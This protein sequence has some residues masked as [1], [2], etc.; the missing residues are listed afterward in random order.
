MKKALI[1]V[2]GIACLSVLVLTCGDHTKVDIPSGDDHFEVLSVDSVAFPS[3]RNPSDSWRFEYTKMDDVW[4]DL[5][6]IPYLDEIIVAVIDTGVNVNHPDLNIMSEGYDFLDND[7]DPT[8]YASHGTHVAG[9]IGAKKNLGSDNVV[10]IAP[11]V[12]ILPLKVF[13]DS[14]SSSYVAM[15]KAIDYAIEMD[16]DVINISM[17][18]VDIDDVRQAVERAEAAGVVVVAA[19]GNF[20]NHWVNGSVYHERYSGKDSYT[21]NMM[22]PAAN[23][24]VLAVG[25]ISKNRSTDEVAIADYSNVG[26]VIDGVYRGVDV[27]A[28]GSGIK[29]TNYTSF[30]SARN[31]SGTSMAAPHVSGMV[32]LLLA[33]YP[34]LTPAEVRAII[35]KTAYDP[36]IVVPDHYSAQDRF[37]AIGNGIIDINAALNFSPLNA[38]GI[39]EDAS[40][41]FDP[42]KYNYLVNV[43]RGVDR[44]NFTCDA[45][46]GSKFYYRGQT[47]DDICDM[48]I[49]LTGEISVIEFDVA[50]KGALRK[51]KFFVRY[52]QPDIKTRIQKIDVVTPLLNPAYSKSNK[53]HYIRISPEASF[54]EFKIDTKDDKDEIALVTSD[55]VGAYIYN[56]NDK[57]PLVLEDKTTVVG[58]MIRDGSGIETTY[59]M[60]FIK[61]KPKAPSAPYNPSEPVVVTPVVSIALDTDAV[62][63][64]YGMNAEEAYKSYDF[65]ATVSGA[66]KGDVVWSLDDD[67]YV[68]VDPKGLV[69]VKDDLP[70]GLGDFSVR[71]KVQSVIGGAVAEA[72]ILFIEKTPL[73]SV[74]FIAPYIS[75]YED[76]TFRPKNSITRAEVATIFSKIMRL[77]II[78]SG[79][80]KFTDVASDHWVYPYVQSLYRT[81]IFSGYEDGTFKPDAPMKRSEIAQVFSNYW[82]YYDLE[83]TSSH[84][85]NIPDVHDDHW[86]ADA[87]HR[88]YNT[89][90]FTGYLNNAYRPG[91]DTIREE[92][93]YMVNKLIG[94]E[95]LDVEVSNFSDLTLDYYYLGEVE[96]A[97]QFYVNKNTIDS[98]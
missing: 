17:G 16:A 73:G 79:Q 21:Y 20:S 89:R 1:K 32:A 56:E 36:G 37:D 35:R 39:V 80:Q 66:D 50:F 40:L 63:L 19:V 43:D 33:K 88:L 91:D 44:L 97:S 29:S 78:N 83:V 60:A 96:A 51:Y 84:V 90:V 81:G 23:E 30:T 68:S 13:S 11:G 49:K 65:R 86:A 3:D 58:V 95:P 22:F 18:N 9:I 28:P 42:M 8:D 54:L 72:D 47:Y 57:L 64:D 70:D 45:M 24:T 62:V 48:D 87:I 92:L 2:V 85:I 75:G 25:A 93:V 71:L 14:G 7:D 15:I 38:M 27:L 82:D 26:S 53:N 67:R 77:N 41:I 94:R 98:E 12:K 55:S 46:V 69:T 74:E 59:L 52:K 6:T 4:D 34:D 76:N 10:G 5:E 31:K 61:E